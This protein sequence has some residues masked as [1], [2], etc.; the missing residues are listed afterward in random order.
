MYDISFVTYVHSR[1]M[2]FLIVFFG[3]KRIALSYGKK[4]EEGV[5]DRKNESFWYK[6]ICSFVREN[7]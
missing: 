1:K 6:E 7:N 5:M 3:I 2:Q 4:I